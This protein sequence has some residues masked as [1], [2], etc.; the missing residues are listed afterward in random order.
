VVR[1]PGKEPGFHVFVPDIVPGFY[2]PLGLAGF[3]QHSFLIGN[4][5]FDR[6]GDE[7]IRAAARSLGQL[8][9]SFF[10]FRIEPDAEGCAPCVR[11][12]HILARA[13]RRLSSWGSAGVK[14][15]GHKLG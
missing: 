1:P 4:V 8:G 12:E 10:G 11:H 5:G 15:E 7:K 13:F 9:E 3:R 6:I 2:L 14:A